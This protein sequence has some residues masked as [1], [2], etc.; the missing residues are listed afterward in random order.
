MYAEKL[1]ILTDEEKEKM[2]ER[3]ASKNAEATEKSDDAEGDVA[4]DSEEAKSE[5]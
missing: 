4:E 5:M 3:I 1:V 2:A